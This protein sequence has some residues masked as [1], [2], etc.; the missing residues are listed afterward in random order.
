MRSVALL[1]GEAIPTIGQGTFGMGEKPAAH[2]SEVAALRLGIDLGMTHLDTAESY[3]DGGAENVIADAVA[4]Q[5]DQVF[6]T[7]KVHPKHA[8]YADVLKAC[9]R[10]LQ[11]LRTDTIDLYLLH[12]RGGITSG[13]A[14]TH[15]VSLGET[16]KA[17]ELLKSQGKIRRW[18]VSNFNLADLEALFESCHGEQSCCANQINYTISRRQLE[19]ELL[20]YH[21]K[22]SILTIA[23][24]PV[25]YGGLLFS[26]ALRRVA[27]RHNVSAAQIVLAWIIQHPRMVTIPKAVNLDHVRQN[28]RAADI[29]L[30][31][32]DNAILERR[33][34]I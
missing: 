19:T 14:P 21:L 30:T 8:A 6:I 31:Q 11:R 15:V 33:F 1:D 32:S 28:A 16:V 26:S 29:E 18:G 25:G 27:Q 22:N 34:H 17:F 2:L 9:E 20:P 13:A 23:Y 5:R 3:A 12:W 7:S 4:G 10:S 24:A